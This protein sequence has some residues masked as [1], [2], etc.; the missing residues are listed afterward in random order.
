MPE[1][2]A[3]FFLPF[4]FPFSR[5]PQQN[6]TASYPEED[7]CTIRPRKLSNT[8]G[9]LSCFLKIAP[10]RQTKSSSLILAAV[11]MPSA[12]S[13]IYWQKALNHARSAQPFAAAA[14]LS[15]PQQ[16]IQVRWAARPCALLS[17]RIPLAP[18]RHPTRAL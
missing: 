6:C 3:T 12:P 7:L 1:L 2:Q 16:K 13:T 10:N 11:K 15:T 18:A 14:P 17:T 5:T 4:L 8:E 9:F